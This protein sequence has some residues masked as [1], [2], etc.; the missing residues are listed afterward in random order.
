MLIGGDERG[1]RILPESFVVAA[2]LT[3]V[4]SLAVTFAMVSRLRRIDMIEA[5]K[6]AE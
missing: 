2:A 3:L 6:T 4:F 5:L 1:G